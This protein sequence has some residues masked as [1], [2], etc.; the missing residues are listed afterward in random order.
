MSKNTAPNKPDR[1]AG[2]YNCIY[3]FVKNPGKLIFKGPVVIPTLFSRE[4]SEIDCF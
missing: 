1:S 4:I 2:N 3:S